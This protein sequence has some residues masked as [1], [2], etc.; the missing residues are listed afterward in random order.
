[1][2]P[3][4]KEP[5]FIT[6]LGQSVPIT[7][8]A[9]HP[10]YKPGSIKH[11][12]ALI[13]LEHYLL[14]NEEI[15]PACLHVGPFDYGLNSFRIARN[16]TAEKSHLFIRSQRQCEESMLFGSNF[17]KDLDESH[18]CWSTDNRL[19]PGLCDIDEGGPFLN[20]FHTQLHGINILAGGCGTH[21]PTIVLR[22][23][24][25]IDWIESFV[26]DRSTTPEPPIVFREDDSVGLFFKPCNTTSGVAGVCLNPWACASEVEKQRLNQTRV[27]I[28]GFEEDVG[29][30]CCPQSSIGSTI[31]VIENH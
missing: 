30:I 26:L 7:E 24:N 8:I 13:R 5:T 29:Y 22:L 25:Y 12:V 3:G 9:R 2:N 27:T 17:T 14:R 31:R 11:N 19:I 16:V 1:M 20:H 10:Q 6:I 15:A 18:S 28:C 4:G 23:G 21:N